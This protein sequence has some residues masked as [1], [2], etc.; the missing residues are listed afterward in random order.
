MK[1][2][3]ILLKFRRNGLVMAKLGLLAI[4]L[5]AGAKSA[6]ASAD[7]GPAIWNPAYAGH[8][9]TSGNGHKFHVCHDMEGYY[10]STISYFKQSGTQASVHY[11]VNGMKDTTSD[12]PAGELT[13][14]VLEANYAWHVLCWNTH[15]T[16]TEHEGFAS[17]PAWYTDLMYETSTDLARHIAQKFG[18][19][20]DR[21]HIVGH[22]EKKNA[23][24]VAYA[25]ANLGINAT[26]NTHTDPGPNWNWNHYMALVR[27]ILGG[28]IRDHYNAIGGMN[29]FLGDPIISETGTPDG[30][31]RYNHFQGGSIYWTP[32]TGAWSVRGSIRD[33]WQAL[34]W[35]TSVL[36]YPTTDE[37]TT[38][39][40]IGRYNHFN[41][42]GTLG[43]I[44]WTPSLGA[45]EV[46][47]NIRTFWANQ[48][49][50]T[51]PLG[52][53]TSDEYAVAQGRR[54]NFEHG[55]VTWNSS[56]NQTT[57]P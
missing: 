3:T 38:P 36:G 20:Q 8:W 50:E 9:Y 5:A 28:S 35:E 11:C 40:G 22:D 23:A 53:P 15:C 19:P 4:G 31:G 24:W 52:Y 10:L 42:N 16:G 7:Y 43:S 32:S 33:K 21:N 39:D 45:H 14:M 30:I 49:W 56:N 29:S 27:N 54:S 46:H 25:N 13:Q 18:F 34:G 17:N 12:A 2:R 26:C 44:Y 57:S 6:Q 47:G 55:T 41:K 1:P 51:G 37:N 48:G